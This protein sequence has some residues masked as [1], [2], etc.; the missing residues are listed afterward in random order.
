MLLVALDILTESVG[1]RAQVFGP[2]KSLTGRS[3]YRFLIILKKRILREHG[4]VSM[5]LRGS[6]VV[7]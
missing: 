2:Y 3:P 7:E 4:E 5:S 6:C 1:M